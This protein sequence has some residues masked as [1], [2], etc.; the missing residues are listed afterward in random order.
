MRDLLVESI[1]EKRGYVKIVF[2]FPIVFDHARIFSILTREGPKHKYLQNVKLDRVTVTIGGYDTGY[3]FQQTIRGID[4]PNT[5]QRTYLEGTKYPAKLNRDQMV[6]ELSFSFIEGRKKFRIRFVNDF[7]EIRPKPSSSVVNELISLLKESFVSNP[8]I[9]LSSAKEKLR[10]AKVD[11]LRGRYRSAVHN[12]Y[13][14]IFNAISSLQA[15]EKE[16]FYLEHGKISETLE[17]IFGKIQQGTTTSKI[18]GRTHFQRLNLDEYLAVVEE[19]RDLRNLADYKVKFEAG[20]KEQHLAE[21][22]S[23]AEELVAI[24]HYVVDESMFTEY[25]KIVL[26]FPREQEEIPL[27]SDLIDYINR[28]MLREEDLIVKSLLIST[29]DFNA[30]V[31]AYCLLSRNDVYYTKFSSYFFQGGHFMKYENGTY[32][33]QRAPESGFIE[34]SSKTVKKWSATIKPENLE[35]LGTSKQNATQRLCLFFDGCFLEMHIFPDGRIYMFSPLDDT[36]FHS[37]TNAFRNMERVIKKIV[38][39]NWPDYSILSSAIE[40]LQRE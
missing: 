27:P 9:F 7:V 24:S 8:R 32:H 20:G 13:Y 25:G 40:I 21:L 11:F 5:G 39:K 3:G 14:A 16:E 23:K 29:D 15:T 31:F 18:L 36:R 38:S 33:H 4:N 2:R 19:A 1:S 26:H 10:S 17:Q 37:Q 30:T 34:L 12:I 28:P 6:S 22:L 35:R